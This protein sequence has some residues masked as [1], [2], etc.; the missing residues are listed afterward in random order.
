M[1]NQP[2]THTFP[3]SSESWIE[4]RSKIN[5]LPPQLQR[6]YRKAGF[7]QRVGGY[8]EREQLR[9]QWAEQVYADRKNP[10]KGLPVAD[11]KEVFG[12]LRGLIAKRRALAVSLLVFNI[13]AALAGILVPR[14]LGDIVDGVTELGL[15][16]ADQLPRLVLIVGALV[17]AQALLNFAARRVSTIFGQG[18]LAEA[19]EQI[20]RTVLRL[21]LSRVESAATGDLVTRV[22]RDVGQMAMAVRW[23]LPH[24]ILN[25]VM[26]VLTTAALI[27]NSWILALPFLA[28][29]L[30]VVWAA[31]RYL[32]RASRG[33]IAAGA[34]YSKLN[35]TLTET[36]EGI[37]SVEAL[38]LKGQ[39]IRATEDDLELAGQGERYL[40]GMRVKLFAVTYFAERLPLLFVLLL[41]GWGYAEGWLSLGEIT[42]ATIYLQQLSRPL[43]MSI[44]TLNMMQQGVTATSRLLGIATVPPDRE[45]SGEHPSNEHLVGKDLR[46]AYRP[47]HDVLHGVDVDLRPGERLAIV[48]PSGSG[49]STL[50]RLLAGINAPR[51]GVVEVG[52]VD[53]MGLPLD[54][55]RTTVALVTQEHHVFVGSIRDNIVLARENDT[56]DDEVWEAL[57]VVE[58]DD[59]V[60]RLPDGLDTKVGSG[61]LA[62]TPGQAQQIAL[63]R[64]VIADPH[65]LILDEATSLIDP[66]TAR[67]VEGSMSSLLLDRTVVAIAH[68]LHTAH[69]ADRIA[70]VIDGKIAELGSHDEL[71][72]QDGEY[73]KL[74]RA[75]TN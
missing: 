18:V 20:M 17:V 32:R 70:V 51:T 30:V 55:L 65:T 27:V 21:P 52:G 36:I 46:F 43:N 57:R 26:I 58:A 50:G 33:Y 60:R 45:I 31:R 54:E 34:N 71:M 3:G 4:D 59:W 25:S 47:G 49:K 8:R 35:S 53:I 40:I 72:A 7:W 29:L 10:D 16:F 44:A 67:E 66:T 5:P 12:F 62:L 22:T 63:A 1:P 11:T 15:A 37:R 19:R 23:A 64:L 2:L 42:A 24:F 41:G 14:R 28:Y 75:W 73:A 74:W 6:D 48:G 39:R 68:R 69:D 38:S 13:L 56:N 61:K 9:H